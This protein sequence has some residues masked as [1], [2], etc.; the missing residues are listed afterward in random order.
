[1]SV[2]NDWYGGICFGSSGNKKQ[3][4]GGLKYVHPD[5]LFH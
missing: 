5:D 3:N 4:H 2:H 1:M